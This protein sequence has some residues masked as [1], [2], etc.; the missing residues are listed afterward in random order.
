MILHRTIIQLLCIWLVW[1]FQT[2]H[3]LVSCLG[4]CA[5][6]V[7]TDI[8]CYGGGGLNQNRFQPHG[9]AERARRR[10]QRPT[11]PRS[12]LLVGSRDSPDEGP[13]R[14]PGGRAPEAPGFLGLLRP[15]N[16]PPRIICFVCFCF[17]FSDKFC[18]KIS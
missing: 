6:F 16:A 13:G 3:A 9:R 17:H 15:Q 11:I 2:T 10:V 4:A 12:G 5:G 7:T 8:V 18:C 1:I 14:G